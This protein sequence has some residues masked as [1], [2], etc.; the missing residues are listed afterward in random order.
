MI[1]YFTQQEE[2]R[3]NKSIWE[4]VTEGIRPTFPRLDT[5][6]SAEVLVVGGGLVGILCAYQLAQAGKHVVVC[7]GRRI[8]QGATGN[9]TAKVTAQHG[10]LYAD[11]IKE[12]NE[13]KAR[14]Y[15]LAQEHAL[16]TIRELAKTIHCDFEDKTAY[17]YASEQKSELEKEA[18]A[19]DRLGIPSVYEES[20]NLPVGNVAALGMTGQAQFNP[21]LFLYGISDGLE[22]Y[23]NTFIHDI[24]DHEAQTDH[25]T[26]KADHIVLAT[27]YPLVNIPGLYFMK[28]NQE[29]SYALALEDAP[30]V[31]GMY[32][33]I[34]GQK[35]SFRNYENLLIVGGG[36]HI[37]GKPGGQYQE[38]RDFTQKALPA[39]NELYSWATQDCMS[40]DRLPY[41]GMHRSD[42][43][44]VWVA[45]GF[46]KWGM[47]NAM[48]S[49][50]TITDLITT[51]KS[52]NE[53]LFQASRS[54]LHDTLFQRSG[55][56]IQGY[57]HLS[58]RCTHMGCAL[59]HN[60]VEN[61]WDCP[62]H[63]SRFS[64]SGSILDNPAKH[65]LK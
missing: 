40:L 64:E 28:L 14:R 59:H 50:T 6:I 44:H 27:H 58:K 13:H 34:D 25:G 57:L 29:R 45:S 7:E 18:Q 62:C 15:Y 60:E 31:D 46:N 32:I 10:L 3:E 63:G 43:P 23:E 11:L 47:T 53:E 5:S 37:T 22:I 33:G 21:L 38:I 36:N 2:A 30:D 65:P 16:A 1:N 41:V 12:E 4:Q 48:M 61:S 20:L 19:Y 54:I 24:D 8:G 42:T 35:L 17:L 51:G 49:A 39:C 52:E 55:E 56:T 9:T 26:I